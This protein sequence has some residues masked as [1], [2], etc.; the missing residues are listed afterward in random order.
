MCVCFLKQWDR[1]RREF[2]HHFTALVVSIRTALGWFDFSVD[3]L[4][5][6]PGSYKVPLL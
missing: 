3:F 1:I 6:P 4:A 2:V 5:L